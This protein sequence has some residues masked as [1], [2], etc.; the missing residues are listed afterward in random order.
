MKG[1]AFPLKECEW[2]GSEAP[3]GTDQEAELG[4]VHENV[5]P[6]LL[7]GRQSHGNP[8]SSKQESKQGFKP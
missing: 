6:G 8:H 1:T 4:E 7:P 2:E 3:G 5:V